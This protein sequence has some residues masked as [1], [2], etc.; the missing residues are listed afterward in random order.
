MIDALIVN[1]P[2]PHPDCAQVW[3]VEYSWDAKKR[4]EAIELAIKLLQARV[5]V[6]EAKP[7]AAEGW[8]S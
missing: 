4:F 5:A 7:L 6:L 3:S 8:G 2:S 1:V